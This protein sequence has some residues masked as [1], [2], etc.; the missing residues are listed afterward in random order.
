MLFKV[1]HGGDLHYKG[2]SK[3]YFEPYSYKG[4][5]EGANSYDKIIEILVPFMKENDNYT[6]TK[7]ISLDVNY[8]LRN[9]ALEY[10]AYGTDNYWHTQ[11]NYF[12]FKNIAA[13]KWYFIIMISIKPLVMVLQINVSLLL[14]IIM[15]N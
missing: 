5:I 9:M 3:E 13:N 8:F 11:G 1:N 6:K 4:D 7:S 14:L 12:L 10:L 2:T 15:L